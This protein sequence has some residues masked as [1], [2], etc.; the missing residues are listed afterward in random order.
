[1]DCINIIK[2]LIFEKLNQMKPNAASYETPIC[3]NMYG[4]VNV[5]LIIIIKL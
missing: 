2:S 1:M 3:D 4:I 5:F